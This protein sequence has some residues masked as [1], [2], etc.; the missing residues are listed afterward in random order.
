MW[1]SMRSV[2]DRIADVD[3]HLARLSRVRPWDRGRW[4]HESV[5]DLLANR[6]KLMAERDKAG[7]TVTDKRKAWR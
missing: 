3:K 1:R 7:F 2:Q 5:E 6:S 4:W